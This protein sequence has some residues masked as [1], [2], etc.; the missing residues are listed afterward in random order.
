MKTYTNKLQ[1]QKSEK[2]G[3]APAQMMTGEQIELPLFFKAKII[4]SFKRLFQS[5]KKMAELSNFTKKH[6]IKMCW[7][8][9][10][11]WKKDFRENA[12]VDRMPDFVFFKEKII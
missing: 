9:F 10:R 2:K 5:A 8:W 12:D 1:I 4:I 11:S 6:A 7:I 3:S